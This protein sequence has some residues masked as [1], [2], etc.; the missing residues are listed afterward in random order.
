MNRSLSSTIACGTPRVDVLHGAT[1][2]STLAR[3]PQDKAEVAFLEAQRIAHAQR[4]P[5]L[6]LRS[7]VSLARLWLQ[8]G[9][10]DCA[11]TLIL[12]T[13]ECCRVTIPSPN[14]AEAQ[15]LIDALGQ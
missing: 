1:S 13:R 10:I 14:L 7:I 8:Q 4:S 11:R 3:P 15:E 6:E 2:Q 12:G 9:K 5:S